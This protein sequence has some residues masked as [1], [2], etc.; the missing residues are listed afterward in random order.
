M[1]D[2]AVREPD[3]GRQRNEMP[4]LPNRKRKNTVR[5]LLG[6]KYYD[7]RSPAASQRCKRCPRS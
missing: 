4:A 3:Q 2:G 7:M 5:Q 6:K 1:C